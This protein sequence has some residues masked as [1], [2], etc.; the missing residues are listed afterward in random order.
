MN[1]LRAGRAAHRKAHVTAGNARTKGLP[2][3]G[4]PPRP[5]P[6][7]P[8]PRVSL[9][10][11][12]R[13]C[14][15][16]PGHPRKSPRPEV[17]VPSSCLLSSLPPAPAPQETAE[18][19]T[20]QWAHTLQGLHR[21][22]TWAAGAPGPLERGRREAP[23]MPP[24][25]EALPGDLSPFAPGS[26]PW[27]CRRQ[28]IPSGPHPALL[29]HTEHWHTQDP[30]RGPRGHSCPHHGRGQTSRDSIS[31]A[32]GIRSQCAQGA[33]RPEP[34]LLLSA[35][36]TPQRHALTVGPSLLTRHLLLGPCLGAT[37]I[38][39]SASTQRSAR[40]TIQGECEIVPTPGSLHR[41]PGSPPHSGLQKH[42]EMAQG[43]VWLQ[44][45]V[46]WAPAPWVL[47]EGGAGRGHLPLS[48]VYFSDLESLRAPPPG[49]GKTLTLN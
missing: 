10:R 32:G 25:W 18:S 45:A 4:F 17:T 12:P 30:L 42:L 15:Y 31:Q 39:A 48:R 27:G 16:R 7:L 43:Q 46:G 28:P 36:P 13:P 14:L 6:D 47:P 19:R 41:P 29:P 24:P 33:R 40:C 23:S 37:E 9:D 38:R 20:K 44:T 26:C 11:A 34:H 2:P 22:W 35:P 3:A 8:V 5:A 1:P 49:A 21:A